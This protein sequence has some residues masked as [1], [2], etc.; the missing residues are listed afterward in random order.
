MKPR[1]ELFKRARRDH[2]RADATHFPRLDCRQARP[3]DIDPSIVLTQ[4][5]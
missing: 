4:R 3:Q 1:V 2:E 5:V